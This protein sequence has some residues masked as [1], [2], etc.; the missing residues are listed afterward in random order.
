M[1]AS[2]ISGHIVDVLNK[3]IFDGT[4]VVENNKIVE[5]RKEEV[6]SY[7]PYILPGFVDSHIHIESTLLTPEHYAALAVSKGVLAVVSD[8]H[9]IANVT[10]LEGVNF[11]IDNG[12]KV[13]FHFYFGASPCVPC[14]GFETAGAAL[15]SKDIEELLKR[16]EIYGVA[17]FM[18]AFG[19]VN[20]DKEC[21]AKLEAARKA[22]KPVD[23]HAPGLTGN[24]LKFYAA[25]GITSDHECASLEEG[26]ERIANGMLVQIRQGSAAEDYEILA[27]LLADNPGK[28]MFCSDDKYPN[29]LLEGYLDQM[30]AHSVEKGY[31]M[32]NVL[33]AAC[34]T[35]VKHYNLKHGLLQK[36]DNADFILVDNLKNFNVLE[37]WVDGSKVYA[38]GKII[39]K[40]FCKDTTPTV[41][42]PNK[43][44]AEK[45][46]VEDLKVPCK[47]KKMKVI[48]A[49]DLS[50]RTGVE[51][52]TPKVENGCVVSDVENDVLKIVVYN[53]YTKAKPQVAFI[54][55]FQL[56]CGAMGSTISHDSHNIVAIG[57]TDQDIVNVINIL[58][59]YKGGLLIAD[60]MSVSGL[61]LPVAGLMSPLDGDVVA[62]KYAALRLMA[63]SQG[64]P[65]NAPFMTMAFMS[66]PVIPDLKITDKGLFDVN[67]FSFTNL[68]EQ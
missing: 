20:G 38:G 60:G 39:E 5:I 34:V 55:G 27:P 12:K 57:A 40:N 58:I 18:N 46:T 2:F 50:L 48:T 15:D 9:E 33:E 17:E 59:E 11:M 26:K 43:F 37:S 67:S 53:R 30:V 22:G 19:V 3:T 41:T 44:A 45:I 21:M 65:F 63:Q 16:D 35:P 36:G 54:K 62:K 24:S 32:W 14:T 49:R 10:G 7:A 51:I 6:P 42:F 64:C 28:V 31:P 68:M 47:G 1:K 8:P 23:G 52:V 61:A 56:K 66:L 29:E 25:H 4:V 13:H